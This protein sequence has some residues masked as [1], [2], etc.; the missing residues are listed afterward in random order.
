MLQCPTRRGMNT[1]IPDMG[2]PSRMPAARKSLA[3][4]LPGAAPAGPSECTGHEMGCL[5]SVT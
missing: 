4:S 2:L 1:Y 5:C 3:Q